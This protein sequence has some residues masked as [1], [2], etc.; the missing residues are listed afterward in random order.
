[1]PYFATI[2]MSSV[3]SSVVCNFGAKEFKFGIEEF[4]LKE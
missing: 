3:D 2:S 1:M 4:I